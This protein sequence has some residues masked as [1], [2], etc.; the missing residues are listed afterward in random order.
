MTD[1]TSR[2]MPNES[3]SRLTDIKC[4]ILIIGCGLG[5]LAAAIAIR[6]F[7]HEVTILEKRAQLQEVGLDS[8]KDRASLSTDFFAANQL[9]AGINISPNATRLF[10]EWGILH[11]VEEKSTAPYAAFMRSYRDHAELSKQQLGNLMEEM[12]ST[13]YLIIHRADLHSI[14]LQEAKR[15]GVIVK[16]DIQF[17]CIDF[18]G[19]SVETSDG[20]KY[21]AD[22]VIGA[23]GEKSACRD[24]LYGHSLSPRDSGDHVLRITVKIC[25][26]IQH[27]DLVDLVQPPCINFWVGPDSFGMAYPLKKDDVLSVT[28]TH[29]HD[30]STTV[31]QAPEIVAI[32]DAR[33]EFSQWNKKFQRVLDLAQGCIKWTL[34]DTPEVVRWTHSDGK[35]ALLGDSAHV[36]PP[37][38]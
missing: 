14:L 34:C 1:V 33:D 19:P 3:A 11:A 27:D 22:V 23:D 24:A 4:H 18:V 30:P 31:E 25:D 35:F 10:R 12:Y 32:A 29:A 21:V 9:G 7:G 28:L 20:N 15:I 2:L 38:L 26:L 36:M 13:P 17:T 6:K 5:G 8:I 37:F 16:L